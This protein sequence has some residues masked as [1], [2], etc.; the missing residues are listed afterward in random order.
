M[1]KSVRVVKRK[2]VLYRKRVFIGQTD[3]FRSLLENWGAPT[4]DVVDGFATHVKGFFDVL[5]R[6]NVYLNEGKIDDKLNT[7]LALHSLENLIG[8]EEN[9]DNLC[10]LINTLIILYCN[11][12]KSWDV[13]EFKIS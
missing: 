6:L 4:I 13:I 1:P 5:T 7:K 3:K 12:D 9:N 8:K 2:A 11:R 10:D